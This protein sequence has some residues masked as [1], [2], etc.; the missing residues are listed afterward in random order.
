[1]L[2][3]QKINY[4]GNLCCKLLDVFAEQD[5]PMRGLQGDDLFN[6]DLIMA[7]RKEL[8]MTH[9]DFYMVLTDFEIKVKVSFLLLPV[10]ISFSVTSKDTEH[11]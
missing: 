10:D 1:M 9:D 4:Q 11:V 8:G 7:F 5:K 3:K 6:H 2:F